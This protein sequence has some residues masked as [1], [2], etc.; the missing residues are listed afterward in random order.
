M[1]RNII[2]C[3]VLA[4]C[5]FASQALAVGTVVI[6]PVNIRV[7]NEITKKTITLAW[8]ADAGAVPNTVINAATYGL[9]GWYLYSAETNPGA[10]APTADYDIVLNDADGVDVSGGLLMNRSDTVT[11]LVLIGNATHGF[12]VVRSNLTMVLTNNAVGAATGTLILTFVAN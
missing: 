5:L 9:A 11:Q 10:T 7:G 3:L 2:I 1:K 4:I 8:T 6:T 12:P